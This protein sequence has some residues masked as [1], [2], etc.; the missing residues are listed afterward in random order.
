M[1]RAT[2]VESTSHRRPTDFALQIPQ[3]V[4]RVDFMISRSLSASAPRILPTS[5]YA[6]M[7]TLLSVR[8][9]ASLGEEPFR[10]VEVPPRS[11]SSNLSV[12]YLSDITHYGEIATARNNRLSYRVD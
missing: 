1:T 7:C 4:L 9:R 8:L 2:F 5:S 10:R 3:N 6:F 11:P 12:G